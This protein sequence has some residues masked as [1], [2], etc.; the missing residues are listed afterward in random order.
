[1]VKLK[2]LKQLTTEHSGQKKM[3][4]SAQEFSDLLRITNVYVANIK[5]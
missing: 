4:Y 2:N 3:V 1:M 5:E